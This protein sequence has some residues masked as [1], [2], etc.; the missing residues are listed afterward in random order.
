MV[1]ICIASRPIYV[2]NDILQDCPGFRIHDH[3]QDDIRDYVLGRLRPELARHPRMIA[4]SKFGSQLEDL[5]K[6]T[7]DKAE[8]VFI[9]IR[10]VVDE[11][12]EGLCEGYTIAELKEVLESLPSE[13]NDLYKST[14]SRSYRWQFSRKLDADHRRE[15]YVMLQ[16]ALSS[17]RPLT[18]RNFI[19]ICQSIATGSAN[20]E[21]VEIE[22][23]S[24]ELRRRLHSRTGGL[25]EAIARAVKES[26]RKF[27]SFC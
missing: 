10:V 2:F 6:L 7:V 16:V 20:G 19:Q 3:T 11:F 26:D 21:N 27:F 1:K 5:L 12:L 9:W 15:A 25:L 22:L 18:P 17:R 4:K 24:D 8:G 13:M 14:V 23:G